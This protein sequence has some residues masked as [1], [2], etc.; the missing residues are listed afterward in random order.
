MI[1]ST[2]AK[3]L[4]DDAV[5]V[6]KSSLFPLAAVVTPNL[7]EAQALTGIDSENRTELAE[8]LVDMGSAAAIVTGGH[9]TELDA[10][11]RQHWQLFWPKVSH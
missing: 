1:S 3:L 5:A 2:G 6:L 8:A 9:G 11:I 4:E 10:R 7:L